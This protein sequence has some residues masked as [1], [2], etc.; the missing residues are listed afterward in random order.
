MCPLPEQEYKSQGLGLGEKGGSLRK[1]RVLFPEEGGVYTGQARTTDVLS[2]LGY[3]KAGYLGTGGTWRSSWEQRI[4][5]TSMLPLSHLELHMFISACV[6]FSPMSP[7]EKQ[8][9]GVNV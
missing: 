3:S 6:C 8:S 1:I 5:P 2:R 9:Q 4:S 7:A